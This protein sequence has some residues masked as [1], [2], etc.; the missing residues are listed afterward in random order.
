MD[1]IIYVCSLMRK[2]SIAKSVRGVCMPSPVE[3]AS[4][5]PGLPAGWEPS[6]RTLLGEKHC[7]IFSLNLVYL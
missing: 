4:L 3:G 7:T 5:F 1:N 2:C 6:I